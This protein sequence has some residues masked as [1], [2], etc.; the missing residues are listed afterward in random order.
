MK[1]PVKYKYPNSK[2]LPELLLLSDS[3]LPT[4]G[5]AHSYGLETFMAREEYDIEALIRTFITNEIGKVDCPAF[6]LA[7]R[8][9]EK[10]A[11]NSLLDLDMTV[12][13]LKL[14]REWREAG[15]QTGRRLAVIGE[16]LAIVSPDFKVNLFWENYCSAIK[17]GITPGQHPV[18]AG[19]I[20]QRLGLA[21]PESALA[22]MVSV[23]KNI[24]TVAVKLVPLGQTEGLK[25]QC[26]FHSLLVCSV[27]QALKISNSD[28][29]GGFA[30]EFELAGI[31]HES[32]YTRLF[33]S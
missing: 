8:A 24:I 32:L 19:I 26:S 7:Y 18:V 15:A 14:P 11:L 29:L 13:A 5:F 17:S 2:L 1:K 33:I 27:Q 21:I 23:L 22:Y 31:Q 16:T 30:P 6:I 28:E 9:A 20:Y 3:A 4:G 12:N 10:N 25:L